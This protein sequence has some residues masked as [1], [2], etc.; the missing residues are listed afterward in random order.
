MEIVYDKYNRAI[1]GKKYGS[2]IFYGDIE[3]YGDF[4][5]LECNDYEA[6]FSD[7]ELEEVLLFAQDVAKKQNKWLAIEM[8]HWTDP[9][10]FCILSFFSKHGYEEVIGDEELTK[11]H[12]HFRKHTYVEEKE[13]KNARKRLDDYELFYRALD[14]KLEK[15]WAIEILNFCLDVR[16]TFSFDFLYYMQ[17]NGK[18]NVIHEKEA[19]YLSLYEK[20]K[21]EIKKTK[22]ETFEEIST[23]IEDY[24]SFVYNRQKIKN[25][26]QPRKVFFGRFYSDRCKHFL[27]NNHMDNLYDLL[28]TVY[29]PIQMEQYADYHLHTGIETKGDWSFRFHETWISF[30][31]K[32]DTLCIKNKR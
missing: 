22:V 24:F 15:T 26:L 25:I 1:E 29:N 10:F 13:R 20:E 30:D 32:N 14:K 8:D 17:F 18:I 4:M 9:S 31:E 27:G 21:G 12:Y 28:R 11:H 2:T 5:Y 16:S 23:C 7:Q 3:Y 19:M 6:E